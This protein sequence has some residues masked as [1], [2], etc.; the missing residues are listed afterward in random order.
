VT[1]S[2]VVAATSTAA[3][4]TATLFAIGMHRSTASEE[5]RV[6]VVVELFTSEGCSSCPPA[7]KVLT[8]LVST[9]PVAGAQII[10]LGE[11]VDYWDSL[12]WR[13]PFSQSAFSKRQS[14][15]DQTVFRTGQIY[16]PQMVVDGHREF[17]GS[18]MPAARRAIADAV[19]DRVSRVQV[20]A[21]AVALDDAISVNVEVTP[22]AAAM[23]AGEADVYV[24]AIE[25]GLATDVQRGENRGRLLHHSAVTRA[26][27]SIGTTR[28][29]AQW[30]GEGRLPLDPTW[31][32]RALEI[33][34]FVQD[35]ASLR[36]LGAASATLTSNGSR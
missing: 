33:V 25:S 8:E 1:M 20:S 31:A 5:P 15:Y 3:L 27:T 9:Q 12:G 17:I 14:A 24:A 30:S 19:A 13:D 16:T 34:A 4:A 18:S 32:P 7:D 6:P 10:A 22:A 36:I 35:R 2:S 11:H 29:A 26:L 28:T 23:L 21:R